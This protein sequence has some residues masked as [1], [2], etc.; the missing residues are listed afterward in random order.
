MFMVWRYYL[1][2]LKFYRIKLNLAQHHQILGKGKSKINKHINHGFHLVKGKSYHQ[3]EDSVVAEFRN[4]GKSELGLFA[5]FDGH[6]G[7]DVPGYL[8]SHL[9]DNIISLVICKGW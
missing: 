1:F 5:I 4:V 9:F 6:L 8:E 2:C 7:H 3:M